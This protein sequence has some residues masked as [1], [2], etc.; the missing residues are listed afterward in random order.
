V[1]WFE[2]ITGFREQDYATTQSLLC[3]Q[4][5]KLVSPHSSRRYSVGILE[6]PTLSELRERTVAFPRG[7]PNTVRV[8][9]GDA[10]ALHRDRENRG[11]LFQVASQFNLLEMVHEDVTP[12]Q[13][14]TRYESDRTQGPACAIAAGAATIYRNYL[15][16]LEG[17]IGQTKRRQIDCLRDVGSA[18]GN[19]NGHLWQM[20]N[21][22]AIFGKGGLLEVDRRLASL[23]E[24]GIDQLRSKLRIGLHC[25]VDV[26]D[27]EEAH[28][29]SQA[30]CSALPVAY[31]ASAGT[32]SA[33]KRFATLILEAAYEATLLAGMLQENRGARSVVFLTRVGGGAFGNDTE[34]IHEAIR[35]SLRLASGL[36]VRIVT[37]SA[38]DRDLLS[39]EQ[40]A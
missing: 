20:R 13:G 5:G 12:E 23:D 36:D 25:G 28:S 14:I 8:V 19:E 7:L 22:Y 3:V 18:L 38:P 1:S 32:R 17:S 39:L 31:N 16:P 2:K 10:R 29:V 26:T 9:V 40:L 11:A 24:A 27:A 4:A 34:W 6:T 37:F 30:F 21:G 33:W 15:V 35:R